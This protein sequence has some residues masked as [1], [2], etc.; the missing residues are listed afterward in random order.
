[1]SAWPGCYRSPRELTDPTR[2]SSPSFGFNSGFRGCDGDPS[3]VV[4]RSSLSP[5]VC[6]F[7]AESSASPA[8]VVSVS[9]DG[10]P[11]FSSC[12]CI[13]AK[14]RL[15][16]SS[17]SIFDLAIRFSSAGVTSVSGDVVELGV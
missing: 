7:A 9:E 3:G 16:L 12:S 5:P 6:S 10:P 17:S 15:S 1:M 13:F 11:S 2:F 14:G 4:E 8:V